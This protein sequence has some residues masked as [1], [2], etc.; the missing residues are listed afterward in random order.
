VRT[1]VTD[2]WPELALK[3]T[4]TPTFQTNA[5]PSDYVSVIELRVFSD[6]LCNH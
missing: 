6:T 5:Q 2:H 3:M 4:L 1:Q